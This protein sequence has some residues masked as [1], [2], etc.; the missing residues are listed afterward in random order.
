MT[1]NSYVFEKPSC[2]FE[3][4]KRQGFKTPNVYTVTN[5]AQVISLYKEY[6]LTKREQLDYDIDGLVQEINTFEGQKE[7]GYQPNGLN[8]KFA[9][10]IKFDSMGAISNFK[11]VTWNAGM[12]GRIIPTGTFTPVDIMG[13]TVQKASLHNFEFLES[14]IDNEG[15]KVDSEIIVVRSGDVIPVILGVKTAGDGTYIQIPDKCPTCNG[16]LVRFSVDLVCEAL[17]CD[18]KIEGIFTNLFDTL[19]MKGLSTKFIQKVIAKYGITTIDGL[20]RLTVDD[21]E[22]LP[23]FALKSA[24]KAYDIIHSVTVVTPEQFFALLNIPHQG[25]RVFENLFSQVSMEVLL[26]DTLKPEDLIDAKGIAEKTASAIHNGIQSNL[27]RLQEN[28]EWFTVEKKEISS[29]SD[30][31]LT[32]LLG[33]SFCITGTLLKGTR[34]EYETKIKACG[35]S[36]GSVTKKLNY[37]VTNDTSTNSGKLKK[38]STINSKILN[39]GD[40]NKIMVINEEQL[41]LMM[42]E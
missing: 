18:A 38:V 29:I 36:V 4:L 2:K 11:F 33:K 31:H 25:V 9:T 37:L 27:D 1:L 14:L 7:L 42:E 5:S 40:N 20:M 23:G 6:M 24:Q 10:S 3:F 16:D 8:P 35:G 13:V 12:T 22:E 26:S 30:E 28:A 41:R 17:D 21:F 32:V 19:D 39:D 34:K 15:L